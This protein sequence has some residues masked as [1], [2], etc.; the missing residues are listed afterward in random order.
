M[1]PEPQ[2]TVSHICN[3]TKFECN[4]T[5]R[6][7]TR[8]SNNS[9]SFLCISSQFFQRKIYNS[10]ARNM[11]VGSGSG[12]RPKTPHGFFLLVSSKIPKDL[13]FQRHWTPPWRI[14]AVNPTPSKNSWIGPWISL[15]CYMFTPVSVIYLLHCV[16]PTTIPQACTVRCTDVSTSQMTSCRISWTSHRSS[17]SSP[18]TCSRPPSEKC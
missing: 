15:G 4:R 7:F 18:R 1:L 16:N 9:E 11:D 2:H 17:Q 10:M 13:P 8:L 5:A 12:G 3:L 14:P 6:P